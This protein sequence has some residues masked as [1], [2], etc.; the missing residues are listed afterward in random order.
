M[1]M[2]LLMFHTAVSFAEIEI[3]LSGEFSLKILIWS[4][5]GYILD[6]I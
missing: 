1:G 3:K 4:N 5:A 2:V 6:N